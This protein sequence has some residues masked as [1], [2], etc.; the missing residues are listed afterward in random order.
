MRVIVRGEF[1]ENVRAVCDRFGVV[2]TTVYDAVLRGKTDGIGLGHPNHKTG[3]GGRP[4]REVLIGEERYPSVKAAQRALRCD[5]AMIRK[6]LDGDAKAMA[7]LV[8]RL[9]R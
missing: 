2:E 3:G 4:A 5:P 1:F 9:A 6:A 8:A 7:R